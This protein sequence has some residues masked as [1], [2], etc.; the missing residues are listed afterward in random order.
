MAAHGVGAALGGI[1]LAREAL[2]R[3]P[4]EGFALAN[5]DHLAIASGIG[6]GSVGFGLGFLGF[7]RLRKQGKVKQAVQQSDYVRYPP[8]RFVRGWQLD[9]R[10]YATLR[11]RRYVA[12]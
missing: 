2:K 9:W 3:I 6:R 8:F 7:G 1:G 11:G 4:Q 12:D 5:G 10:C